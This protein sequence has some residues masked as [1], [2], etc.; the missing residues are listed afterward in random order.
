MELKRTVYGFTPEAEGFLVRQPWPGNVREL[1]NVVRRAVLSASTVVDLCHVAPL[2][3]AR[4]GDLLSLG[5]EGA[6]LTLREAREQAVRKAESEAIRAALTETRGNK[7][8]AARLLKVDYKT[9]W[10]KLKEY[11]IGVSDAA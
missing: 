3:S 1:R 9:L 11:G 8:A 5:T 6:A 4:S 10:C 2:E 7:T